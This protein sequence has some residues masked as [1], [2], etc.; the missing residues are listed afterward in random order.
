[1]RPTV[2]RFTKDH[3][4]P[5]VQG[6]TH[7]D[8]N[9]RCMLGQ[10]STQHFRRLLLTHLRN[11]IIPPPL[12][13]FPLITPSR[14]L[15]RDGGGAPLLV[16]ATRRTLLRNLRLSHVS[17]ESLK[18][19]PNFVSSIQRSSIQAPIPPSYPIAPDHPRAYCWLG[20]VGLTARGREASQTLTKHEYSDLIK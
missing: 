5:P 12:P 11:S 16:D 2:I 10:G 3:S 17:N 18:I 7:T 20:L 1:M 15:S 14:S 4:I 19:V 9:R 13:R 8:T 6:L